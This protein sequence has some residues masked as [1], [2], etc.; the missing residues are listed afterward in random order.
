MKIKTLSSWACQIGLAAIFFMAGGMK[1]V[2]D[3]DTIRLFAALGMEPAGR[4]VIG[5]LEVLSACLLLWPATAARGAL[6]AFCIMLGALIAH[7]TRI[8][9]GG[10]M[11]DTA[12]MWAL[13]FTFSLLVL[14]FRHAE[15][16][17]LRRA[18]D[19]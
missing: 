16:R 5:V 9:F 1:L 15:L 2:N 10:D 14:A 18:V 11:S 6:L 13:A 7:A 8:G 19:R 4:Y 17:F 12:L 3:T